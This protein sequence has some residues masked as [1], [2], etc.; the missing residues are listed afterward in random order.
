MFAPPFA[1]KAHPLRAVEAARALIEATSR[2]DGDREPI[3]VGAGVHTGIA[4][5]GAIGGEDG[6]RTDLTALGDTVNTTARL[7]SAA[8]A[9]E[10]LVTR[11][12]AE[13]AGIAARCSS[14]DTE[15]R[16][17]EPVDVVVPA[18]NRQR[19]RPDRRV[20]VGRSTQ[21]PRVVRHRT[22][23][24]RPLLAAGAATSLQKRSVPM[25]CARAT[26]A[27]DALYATSANRVTKSIADSTPIA[28]RRR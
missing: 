21:I 8:G 18:R 27:A 2:A 3:P 5:V 24:R 19:R 12:A 17:P 14:S 25:D 26:A 15:L 23:N 6:A 10:I 13:A 9:G 22:S 11:A 4:F 16:G 1:G 28:S 7:A 20:R